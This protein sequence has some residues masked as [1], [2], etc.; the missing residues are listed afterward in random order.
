MI[1][2]VLGYIGDSGGIYL[3]AKRNINKDYGGLWEFQGGKI[4]GWEFYQ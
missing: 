1:N 2:V 3:L 4:E